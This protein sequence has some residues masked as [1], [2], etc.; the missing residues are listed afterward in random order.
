MATGLPLGEAMPGH[1]FESCLV[2]QFQG[3]YSDVIMSAMASQIT[4]VSFLYSIVSSGVDQRKHQRSASLA[5]VRGIHW[6]PVNSPLRGP[7]T[8]NMFPLD[9]VIVFLVS[10]AMDCGMW[11]FVLLTLWGL[12]KYTCVRNM[13]HHWVSLG[14]LCAFNSITVTSWWARWRL[15]SPASR[16]FTQPFVEAQIKENTKAMTGEFPH[17][18]Q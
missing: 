10:F 14:R 6:W 2:L 8:R 15:K 9:D 7:V 1:S 13:S 12:V 18:G 4:G 16:L 3:H 17:E 11:L 5:F